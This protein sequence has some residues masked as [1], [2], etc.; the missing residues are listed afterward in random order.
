MTRLD[1]LGC[2]HAKLSDEFSLEVSF[3][4]NETNT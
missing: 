2:D 4:E 3:E 1:A